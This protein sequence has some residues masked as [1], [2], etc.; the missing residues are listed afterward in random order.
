MSKYINRITLFLI[1]LLFSFACFLCMQ[2]QNGCWANSPTKIYDEVYL[3]PGL[4][5]NPK[6]GR[7]KK[8]DE[9]GNNCQERM[10]DVASNSLYKISCTNNQLIFHHFLGDQVSSYLLASRIYEWNVSHW[11]LEWLN[12]YYLTLLEVAA[13]PIDKSKSYPKNICRGFYWVYR[14]ELKTKMPTIMCPHGVP[15]AQMRLFLIKSEA[16]NVFTDK[17]LSKEVSDL[18]IQ[19]NASGVF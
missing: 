4:V 3:Y 18:K 1:L 2:T 14:E 13:K 5:Q 16:A 19:A 12:N 17:K 8:C 10:L 9:S 11:Q 7:I 6:D 15:E